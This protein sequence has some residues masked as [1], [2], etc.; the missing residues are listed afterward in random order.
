MTD[1]HPFI[2]TIRKRLTGPLPGREAQF[3]MAF[4]HRVEELQRRL[5]PPSNAKTACV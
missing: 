2:Q 4:A 5:N 3:K 1:T